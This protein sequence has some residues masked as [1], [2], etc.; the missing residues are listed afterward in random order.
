MGDLRRA[1]IYARISRDAAGD[2]LGVTRQ[3]KDC[4]ALVAKRGWG[5]VE[6]FIDND[7][8]AFDSRKRR[9]EYQRLVDGM[10]ANLFDVV[11]VWHPDRLH[12]S[13]RE[14][15]DFIDLIE[16]TGTQIV[17]VTAGEYDLSTSEGRLV[18]RM[19]G[20]VAR[21]ESEDKSR[22]LRRKHVEIAE[23][24]RWGGGTVTYGY[25]RKVDGQ[26]T[27]DRAA[28]TVVKE[29]ARRVLAGETLYSI[30]TDFTHRNVPTAKGGPWRTPTL[31]HILTTPTVA[32][33]R[34]HRGK[35]SGEAVWKPILDETTWRQVCAVLND[36]SK[37]R[38][39]RP[40]RSYLLTGGLA[41]CG[42]CGGPLYAQRR[43]KTHSNSGARTYYCVPGTDKSGCGKIMCSA[44]PLEQEVFNRLK[45]KIDVAQYAH[46]YKASERQVTAETAA[47]N[48]LLSVEQ[49]QEQLAVLWADGQLSMTEWQAA[50]ARLTARLDRVQ[51]QQATNVQGQAAKKM[52]K[53]VKDLETEWESWSFDKRRAALE[54]FVKTVTVKPALRRGR[55]FDR[56]R[57][58][59]EWRF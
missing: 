47:E 34:S 50:K 1:A 10:K 9:P 57:V 56:D 27:I 42:V 25:V 43:S 28:A 35:V 18:A 6:T 2:E 23:Q 16:A 17:T 4:E 54:L 33:L 59:V 29:A 49:Q 12:R 15:E 37:A 13:T 14:L 31:K 20:A 21:K 46:Q 7:V 55:I 36:P 44:E 8:S 26:P 19:V 48:E 58:E 5:V 30:C 3:R 51:E 52:L 45:R 40:V 11:V 22:R 41:R 24:G 38:G 32:G 53:E 39:S